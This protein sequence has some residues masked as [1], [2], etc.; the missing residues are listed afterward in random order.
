MCD[1]CHVMQERREFQRLRLDPP[2]SGTVAGTDV[3]I[4]EIG[5]LGARVQ[6]AAAFPVDRGELRFEFAGQPVSM[7]CEIVRTQGN[8]SGVRFTAAVGESGD[9]LRQML[10][11]LVH[12]ELERRRN[13]T[14]VAKAPQFVDGDRTIRGI[15]AGYVTYRLEN[16]FWTRRRIFLP[17]QPPVGF[18]VARGED[19]EEM[20]RLC[21]VY[22]ASDEEG[23]RLIRL[24][25]ELSISRVLEIPPKAAP[26]PAAS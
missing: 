15:D 3:R 16:N 12:Y 1:N 22:Q 26:P 24:F 9:R 2:L 19:V 13:E 7:R 10:A 5:I 21:R 6:H 8:E 11:E 20:T 4:V 18:T 23:R 14:V 17:E 25:A